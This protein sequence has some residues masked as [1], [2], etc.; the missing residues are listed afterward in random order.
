[1]TTIQCTGNTLTIKNNG[2]TASIIVERALTLAT[3]C[4]VIESIT[5]A[6]QNK[7]EVVTVP[8]ISFAH[9]QKPRNSQKLF[10]Q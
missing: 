7:G 1:M 2:R 5:R 9:G 8:S 6:W 10:V 4:D 3:D